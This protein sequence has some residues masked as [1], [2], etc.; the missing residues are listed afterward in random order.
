MAPEV[1]REERYTEKADVFRYL[2][3]DSYRHFLINLISFGVVMW[4]MMTGQIPYEG[5]GA[6]RVI[7]IV[8]QHGPSLPIPSTVPTALLDIWKPCVSSDAN[9]RQVLT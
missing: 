9:E 3:I 8:A 4:E 5:I 6:L 7:A 2:M 1:L